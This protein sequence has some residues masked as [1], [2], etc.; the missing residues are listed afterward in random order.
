MMLFLE[1]TLISTYFAP[2]VSHESALVILTL[3][4]AFL[5][6]YLGI[7]I[8]IYLHY[9]YELHHKLVLCVLHLKMSAFHS[10]ASKSS[11]G[12]RINNYIIQG[13]LK[14]LKSY[15]TDYIFH[16]VPLLLTTIV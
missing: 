14:L 6:N 9:I 11:F 15:L 12:L 5:M 7:L 16:T 13:Y 4:C 1:V 10:N 2:L 8:Y 3:K